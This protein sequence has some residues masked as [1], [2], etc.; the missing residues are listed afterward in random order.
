[1]ATWTMYEGSFSAFVPVKSVQLRQQVL[2]FNLWTRYTNRWNDYELVNN[3]PEYEHRPSPFMGACL[4]GRFRF[5]GYP[6]ARF[7]DCAAWLYT[8]EYRM[9]PQWNPLRNWKVMQWLNVKTDWIQFV[10]FAESGRVAPNWSLKTFHQDMKYDAGLGVRI[11]ANQMII[12]V[13]SAFSPEGPQLQM[14]I[15]QSF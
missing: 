15:S 3:Y 12:R 4:G 10:A 13:D 6:E 11:F 1:T 9:I 8:M 7:N 14:F 5:R 2:A